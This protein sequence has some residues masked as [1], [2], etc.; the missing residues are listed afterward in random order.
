VSRSSGCLDHTESTESYSLSRNHFNMNKFG[1]PDEEDYQT[2]REIVEKMVE[3][4]QGIVR[5][6]MPNGSMFSYPED[7]VGIY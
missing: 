1:R 6:R 7:F 4:A 5:A 2:V 3:N